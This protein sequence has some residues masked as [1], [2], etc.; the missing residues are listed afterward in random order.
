MGPG[1]SDNRNIVGSV[2]GARTVLQRGRVAVYNQLM[3]KE[4]IHISEAEAATTNVATLLAHV[5]AGADVVIENDARPVAVLRSAEHA[6]RAV[7]SR[8]PS[9]WQKRMRKS[10][11]TNLRSTQT[12]P[13][14]SKRSSIAA[15]LATSRHG[16]NPR[17]QRAHRRG[18]PRGKCAANPQE[19]AGCAWR[20]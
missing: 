3:A 13:P 9:R 6:R 18:A 12:S 17:L 14:T 1:V 4:V 8:N 16:S 5:R 10:W 11:A 19:G 7:C 20:S 15:N 2:L